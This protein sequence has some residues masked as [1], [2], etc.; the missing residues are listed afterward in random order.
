MYCK[1]KV[2]REDFIY[3]CTDSQSIHSTKAK[4]LRDGENKKTDIVRWG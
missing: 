4:L 1:G 2:N 3:T